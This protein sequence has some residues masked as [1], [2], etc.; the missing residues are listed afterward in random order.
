M[1]SQ[2]GVHKSRAIKFGAIETDFFFAFFSAAFPLH[3]KMSISS[4]AP[5]RCQITVSSTG[6]KSLGR[7]CG[8]YSLSPIRPLKFGGDS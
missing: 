5:K 8:T 3:I 1:E 2:T 4:Y 7:Q 6:R